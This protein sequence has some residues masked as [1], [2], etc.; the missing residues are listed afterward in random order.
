MIEVNR[1]LYVRNLPY[2]ITDEEMYGIFGRYGAVRQV[3]IG[4]TPQT[5]GTAYVV[6]ED[7]FDARNAQGQLSGYNLKNRYLVVSYHHEKKMRTKMSVEEQ[8]E[9]LRRMQQAAGVDGLQH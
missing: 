4:D 7:I 3:R 9:E 2:D 8:E 1:V 5:K 6:Y